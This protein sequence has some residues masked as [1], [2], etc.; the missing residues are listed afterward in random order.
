[1]TVA[2]GLDVHVLVDEGAQAA[3]EGRDVGGSY[4]E[5]VQ[6]L[7]W[8]HERFGDRL[9]VATSMTDAVLAHLTSTVIP[10][11]RLAFIDTGYHFP[12]TL[13]MADA[14]EAS[15]PVNLLRITPVQSVA[16]QDATRGPRLYERNPDLCCALRKVEPLNRVLSE[17]DAWVSGLRREDAATRTWIPTVA[18]D[19]KRNKVKINPIAA[20]TQADVDAYIREHNILI[21]PLQQEGYLS[22]GCAPCTNPVTDGTDVRAGRWS[23]SAKTE[24]GMHL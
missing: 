11:V 9:V 6:V 8:A 3:M 22:I 7:E 13:G 4:G 12:E 15:H 20:W 17:H 5:A 10:S 21:N 16:E 14:V 19:A 1:M 23:N 24:C 2:S 18:I